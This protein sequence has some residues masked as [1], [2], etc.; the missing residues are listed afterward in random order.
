[1][2]GGTIESHLDKEHQNHPEAVEE[3]R[4]SLY[5]DDV[6]SGDDD[7]E[8]C[9]E[10]KVT[11]RAIFKRAG[12]DL[13]KWHSNIKELEDDNISEVEEND[14]T[15]AKQ[16]LAVKTDTTS[17]LGL[18][19]DKSA[20]ELEVKFPELETATTKRG[21]LKYLASIYDP[22]GI[23]SPVLLLGKMIFREICDL[24]VGWDTPLP[25][26]ISN[27]WR[28]WKRQLPSCITIP[29]AI[30][31][32]PLKIDYIDIHTFG[33]ASKKGLCTAIYAVVKQGKKTYQGLLAAKARLAKKGLTIPRLELVSAHMSANQM[34]NAKQ[35]LSGLPI[36]RTVAWS[37]STVALHWIKG[38][39]TYKQFVK[40]R[41]DKIR[42]KQ[43]I[44]WR[45]VSSGDNPA[46]IGSRG[47]SEAKIPDLWWRGP[48]WL[49]NYEE[50]PTDIVTSPTEETESEAKLVQTVLT[51]AIPSKP[52]ELDKV[53]EKHSYWRTMRV[54][55]FVQRFIS[56]C[57][58]SRDARL[59]GPLTTEEIE[60]AELFWI[61]REQQRFLGSAKFEKDQG[62]LNLQ[63]DGRGVYVCRGR[64]QGEYPIYLPSEC[65]LSEKLIKR[66]WGSW[67][68]ND[69]R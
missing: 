33:D 67:V 6:I 22:L 24:K 58:K 65:I 66:A 59:L 5:I 21:I 68:H 50:W 3:L 26:S 64:I 23:T 4:K 13:H 48:S 19:W 49:Q 41:S 36:N 61:K 30:P 62:M 10:Y 34:D 44:E 42:E 53:L 63:V 25:I 55:A 35:A 1:M 8:S 51:T 31:G 37:D 16:Q 27:Q 18:G 46:D 7:T 14:S 29:R 2:L 38:N 39:G 57:R 40:S 9:S 28:Q 15:F 17:I 69:K 20:D 12:F 60:T 43:G 11:I 54:T 52:D 32:L 47:S 56:N 45:H